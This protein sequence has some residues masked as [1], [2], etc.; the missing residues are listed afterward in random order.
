MREPLPLRR[1]RRCAIDVDKPGAGEQQQLWQHVL[2]ISA[3][4][5]GRRHVDGVAVQFRLSARDIRMTGAEIARERARL[6]D[7]P[8]ALCGARAA[9]WRASR[10]DDLA[11]R[12]E[13]AAGWDDL[14]LPEAQ[15]AVLR[16]IAAQVRHR[17]HAST[18]DWGFAAQER[19]RPRH[20][21]A[22]RRRQRH[23]QDDGRRGARRASCGLDLYRIDLSQVVSKYIGETEKNLRRVFDAAEDGGA[24]LLFD[25]ADA[26][27]GKRSEVKDSHDRYANIEV[28]YLLQRMEAYRGLA[29]LTTNLKAALDPAFLRR[30]RFVV[31]FPFP[32]ATAAAKRSGA[33]IFPAATPT[34]GLD[35]AQAGAAQRGR[36]QH[37]QHRAE[38]RL[39]RGRAR[40]AG[41]HGAPAAGRPRGGRQAGAS[42]DRGRDEG[43][44]MSRIVVHIE[45][46][47]L[48]GI[49]HHDRHAVAAGLREELGRL[50]GEAG[51]ASR[52]RSFGHASRLQ[53]GRVTLAHGAPPRAVGR[54]TAR[55]IDGAAPGGGPAA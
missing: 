36:R 49:S 6:G 5:A 12:I 1:G 10:L 37:P 20:Q 29:I 26:L 22:L 16:E 19:A 50:W 27:F 18:S 41:R 33:R 54:A 31:H 25:E 23:R 30:L 39:P 32:D 53:L 52:L 28:S 3:D 44:G 55:A 14:V 7:S 51:A 35:Y 38:R 4:A 48:R 13:P 40:R 2:G 21:R 8:D 34:R 42:V 43:M 47:V 11:Q 46:L 15:L 24:I 17:A 45:S 9:A